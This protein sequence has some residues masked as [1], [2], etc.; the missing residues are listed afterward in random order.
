MHKFKEICDAFVDVL[1]SYEANCAINAMRA[2]RN[3]KDREGAYKILTAIKDE[4]PTIVDKLIEEANATG[5]SGWD[6]DQAFAKG[7]E[8][9]LK[10]L[11]LVTS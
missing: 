2:G 5:K 1:E 9:A 8:H 11:G 3:L 10:E 4:Q 7:I 6:T